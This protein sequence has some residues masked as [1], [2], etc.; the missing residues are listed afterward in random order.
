ML[1][2]LALLLNPFV[3][4]VAHALQSHVVVVRR[5]AQRE[6]G[7]EGWQRCVDQVVD[8]GLHLSGIILTNLG[9]RG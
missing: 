9:T 6:V 4:K 5:E 8:S 7:V 1:G 2:A 3:E